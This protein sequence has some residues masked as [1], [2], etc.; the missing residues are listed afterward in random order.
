MI[1]ASV[2]LIQLPAKS[3]QSHDARV[4]FIQPTLEKE[5]EN[6]GAPKDRQGAGTRG[7][8]P[9]A[10][11]PLTALIPLMPT[12]VNQK[13]Q[14]PINTSTTKVA[15]GLTVSEFPTFWFYFPYTPQD[16]NS[17]K[18]ILLDEENNSLTPEPIPISISGTPGIISVR[19]P[20]STKPLEIGKYYHWYFLIDCNP[21]SRTDDF[22]LEGLVKRIE[23][24]SDLTNRFKTTK[25]EELIVLY[26]QAG[27]WH[28]A[29]TLLGELRRSKPKDNRLMSDWQ[30]LL[31]SVGL[32]EIAT[33]SITPCC[34]P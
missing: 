32:K 20:S 6:R 16:V 22:A 10:N 28:D 24:N 9:N 12:N 18:F 1:F 19:L 23:L 2:S 8:C 26:A 27:I 21:Q 30:D 4:R 33:Q 31:E 3:Q 25:P 7:N 34:N 11:I 14:K 17:V 29:V 15:L 13:Q 5:P